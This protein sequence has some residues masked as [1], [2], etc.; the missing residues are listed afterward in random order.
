MIGHQQGSVYSPFRAINSTLNL[1][2]VEEVIS[3]P[4]VGTVHRSLPTHHQNAWQI[5]NPQKEVVAGGLKQ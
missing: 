1:S 4:T 2:C 3:Y 5:A